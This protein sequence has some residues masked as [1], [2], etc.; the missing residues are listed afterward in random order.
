MGKWATRLAEKTAAPPYAGTV[1]TDTSP[2]LSV[3]S[4]TPEGGARDLQAASVPAADVAA[5]ADAA[6]AAD[7]RARLLRWGWPEA[8]A[9]AA[10][11]VR[12]D[13]EA[14]P[15]VSCTDCRHYRPG[16]CGN[17][18]AAGLHSHELGGDLAAILQRCAGF[19]L[20]KGFT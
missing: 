14:D 4:V 6:L 15:R 7:R 11:L 2:L 19:G 12:R 20:R 1:K 13:R 10:R 5:I 9:L 8:E 17:H 18:K 16:R 3:L